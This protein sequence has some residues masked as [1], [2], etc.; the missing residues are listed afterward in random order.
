MKGRSVRQV[1]EKNLFLIYSSEKM[2]IAKKKS[3]F[4]AKPDW[5]DSPTDVCAILV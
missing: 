2:Y 3:A 1:K 4:Q 5:L